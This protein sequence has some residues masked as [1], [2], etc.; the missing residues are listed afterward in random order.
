MRKR[1]RNQHFV[2]LAST[3]AASCAAMQGCG[4]HGDQD[5][6][7]STVQTS[8][9]LNAGAADAGFAVV[10]GDPVPCAAWSDSVISNTG[11]IT[12][13]AASVIDSYQSNLGAYGGSNVGSNGAI[14]AATT[15]TNNG[16]VVKAVE[17][18]NTPAGLAVVPVPSGA[19]NLPLGSTSPGSLNI[20]T[21]ADSITLP[22]G[23]YVGSN[24]NVNSP[25]SIKISPAGHVRIWV[26]GNLNL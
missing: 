13:N 3:V 4:T 12:I 11:S 25:G 26:T 21:A 19:V 7:E 10:P 17:R 18:P 20:N 14:Q 16:G 2:L 5:R 9:A 24:I 8:Q 22:P 15:I 6:S 1:Y 23:N